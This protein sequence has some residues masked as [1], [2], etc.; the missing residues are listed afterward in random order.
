MHSLGGDARTA[1]SLVKLVRLILKQIFRKSGELCLGRFGHSKANRLFE[2]RVVGAGRFAVSRVVVAL[3][4]FLNESLP[5][6]GRSERFPSFDAGFP[7]QMREA[8]NP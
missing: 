1:R 7:V 2:A 5:L 8:V 3:E 6:V 4:K